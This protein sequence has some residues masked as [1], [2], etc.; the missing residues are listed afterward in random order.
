MGLG[1]VLLKTGTSLGFVVDYIKPTDK[2]SRKN[3]FIMSTLSLYLSFS[4]NINFEKSR[5]SN[6]KYRI[7]SINKIEELADKNGDG[8][9]TNIEWGV[10]FRELEKRAAVPMLKNYVSL[11]TGTPPKKIL[12]NAEIGNEILIEYI[13]FKRKDSVDR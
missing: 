13:K 8:L 3:F 12:Y 5:E 10:I 11:F 9:V 4:F 6:H 1:N 7:E 2:M